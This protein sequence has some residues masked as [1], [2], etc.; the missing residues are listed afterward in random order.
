MLLAIHSDASYLTEPKARSRAGVHFF[1]SSD[2]QMPPNNGPVLTLCQI[3]CALMS[4][5]YEAKI[6]AMYMNA[7]EA[8]PDRTTLEEIGHPQ[9]RTPMQIDNSATHSVVTKN[10]QPR[11]TKAMDMRFYLLRCRDAQVRFRYYWMPGTQNLAD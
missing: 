10:I 2:R 1:V 11:Q 9:P 3:I 5:A 4:S 7:R 6:E 8:V